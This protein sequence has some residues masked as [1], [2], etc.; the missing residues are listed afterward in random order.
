MWNQTK[1]LRW[2]HTELRQTH[3]V[4]RFEAKCCVASKFNMMPNVMQFACLRYR[5]EL[6][7]DADTGINDAAKC[8]RKRRRRT[9]VYKKPPLIAAWGW[10][11]TNES[12]ST[13]TKVFL[14]LWG[15]P[16]LQVSGQHRRWGNP[17][18]GSALECV[19]LWNETIYA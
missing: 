17:G 19:A 15:F 1:F 9:Q 3:C 13:G 12:N 11:D 2:L 5:W 10:M 7:L 4:L 6:I 8:R 18:S 16:N 14:L